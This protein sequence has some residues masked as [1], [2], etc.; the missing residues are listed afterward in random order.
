MV[1]TPKEF[2]V[3]L[4]IRHA[5]TFQA[6]FSMQSAKR[7]KKLQHNALPI[8]SSPKWIM[9]V[10]FPQKIEQSTVP[11]VLLFEISEN[12]VTQGQQQST[13][14]S[15]QCREV[16]VAKDDMSSVTR[17]NEYV[18]AQVQLVDE[19][20][21]LASHRTTS[22]DARLEEASNL[23]SQALQKVELH[24][25][26]ARAELNRHTINA[27]LFDTSS[28]IASISTLFPHPDMTEHII[29]I[30]ETEA[31]EKCTLHSQEQP[32][33][34]EG[35]HCFP[36]LLSI[37]N[38]TLPT[39]FITSGEP[40]SLWT[41]TKPSQ[42]VQNDDVYLPLAP[43]LMYNLGQ[44]R[45]RQMR[46]NEAYSCFLESYRLMSLSQDI[47]Q[48]SSMV[49]RILHNLGYIQ[50][51]NGNI[52]ASL[53]LFKI[54][55]Q[56]LEWNTRIDEPVKDSTTD[57]RNACLAATL[58]C[59]GVLYFHL[60][61]LSIEY[62]SEY[63]LKSLSMQQ[64]IL[65]IVN[66]DTNNISGMISVTS[67]VPSTLNN[68]GRVHFMNG[69]NDLAIQ[70]SNESLRLRRQILGN[71][72]LD[73]A[74][75]IFNLAHTHYEIQEYDT[76]LSYCQEFLRIT[77]PQLSIRHRDV[78]Y[79]LK[80]IA[81]IHHQ[82][83]NY[84]P[85]IAAYHEALIA[86]DAVFGIHSEV[87]SI[88]NKL[89]NLYYTIN[90]YDSALSMYE[91]GLI[92]EKVVFQPYHL[93]IAITLCNI[94][95]IYKVKGNLEESLC[96]YGQVYIIQVASVGSCDPIVAV[97]LSNIGFLQYQ[98]H[99][100]QSAYETYQEVL[101]IRR[102]AF[103]ENNVHVAATLNS[104]GL[105]LY[106]LGELEMALEK[107]VCSYQIRRN[108]FGDSHS[109]V[110]VNLNNIATILHALGNDEVAMQFYQEALRVEQNAFGPD[111]KGTIPTLL[112]IAILHTK[113][114][115]INDAIC[116]LQKVFRVQLNGYSS[117]RAAASDHQ[118]PSEKEKNADAIK[119]LHKI[120]KLY[121][122]IGKVGEYVDTMSN[123]WR[124]SDT[125]ELDKIHRFTLRQGSN[126]LSND[127][128]DDTEDDTDPDEQN[129]N[130]ISNVISSRV[131]RTPTTKTGI[132][133][134]DLYVIS[135][136]HP[137]LASMA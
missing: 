12:M 99:Q 125:S 91:S 16:P 42:P 134:F 111:H 23:L 123:I 62:S 102:T 43:L 98:C 128:D 68:I 76:A 71:D 35:M 104:M 31:S 117:D 93:N 30:D 100:Y 109:D 26:I 116:Y 77:R 7:A 56:V 94:A 67:L 60:P 59:L 10:I 19:S 92:I 110:A 86:C 55:Q 22:I 4:S 118:N 70:I 103:G 115:E 14:R 131:R 82:Q 108:E 66:G 58:N 41:M 46:H 25:T 97:T 39:K 135:K 49:S 79:V 65:S 38:R 6:E 129:D 106:K 130:F 3:L 13:W 80:C 75:T 34:D 72:H 126:D 78:A 87:A 83:K 85:A 2:T 119:T 37:V 69:K 89:G 120:A 63:L 122:Q 20:P 44:I 95:Q 5:T 29:H 64:E 52:I 96:L 28:L 90:K 9:E 32:E 48:E 40:Q 51:R 50:Y 33:Y 101:L 74:A 113:N 124:W 84:L 1:H 45:K 137:N 121:L 61:T 57:D 132:T 105:V 17:C 114:G 27:S 36:R 107:F 127:D 11:I 53:K 81:H 47:S 133:A 73:V 8:P 15:I 136:L 88:C 54:A 24:S 18:I 21:I 112:Y